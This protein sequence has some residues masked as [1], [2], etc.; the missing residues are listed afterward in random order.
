[1][2]WQRLPPRTAGRCAGTIAGG[3]SALSA[4][5]VRFAAAARSLTRLAAAARA[6]LL[7][8]ALRSSSA[9]CCSSARRSARVRRAR[10]ARVMT[11]GLRSCPAIVCAAAAAFAAGVESS[12]SIASAGNRSQCC[13][14]PSGSASADAGLTQLAQ[15]QGRAPAAEELCTSTTRHENVMIGCI[16]QLA[17]STAGCTGEH[18][19]SGS[20]DS[21]LSCMRTTPSEMRVLA[22]LLP[23]LAD[24]LAPFALETG[25]QGPRSPA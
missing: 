10:A 17:V 15:H 25:A 1:M 7:S 8:A 9:C 21:G 3:S 5:A 2:V 13:P 12:V 11:P 19:P 24:C 6:A 18:A 22:S 16:M 4:A 14:P 20:M 23:E